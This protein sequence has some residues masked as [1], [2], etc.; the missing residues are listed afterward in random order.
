[1][2]IGLEYY[3]H[4]MP[5]IVAIC[6]ALRNFTLHRYES[7]TAV[8]NEFSYFD[9]INEY[10]FT[11][12]YPKNCDKKIRLVSTI[13]TLKN[14]SWKNEKYNDLGT[15]AVSSKYDKIIVT[16][17][18]DG[19]SG[20]TEQDIESIKSFLE[21]GNIIIST[22]F[23]DVQHPNFVH[24]PLLNLYLFYYYFG[25]QYLN[26]YKFN[27]K[28]NLLGVYFDKNSGNSKS[29]RDNIISYCSNVLDEDFL[30]YDNRTDD[31]FKNKLQAYNGMGLWGQNH[32]TSYTDYT[33]SVCNLVFETNSENDDTPLYLTEKTLKSILFGQEEIFFIWYGSKK[34]FDFLKAQGFWFLNT[35]FYTDDIQISVKESILYLKT[36]KEVLK[37]NDEVQ[38]YLLEKYGHNLKN[39]IKKFNEIIE[40]YPEKENILHLLRN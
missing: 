11:T 29:W 8:K 33:T 13:N 22:S 14:Y 12:H 10:F 24:S 23:L 38:Q 9:N 25:F 31:D 5:D 4:S 2:K 6:A 26:Y 36:L 39:N 16:L 18:I 40:N 20:L 17:S 37:S 27:K 15:D 28:N 32:I 19:A 30:I 35:E 21:D 7:V 1:M 34:L 3:R